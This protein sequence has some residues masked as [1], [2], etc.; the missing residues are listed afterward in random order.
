MKMK[1]TKASSKDPSEVPEVSDFI[2]SEKVLQDFLAHHQDFYEELSTLVAD[3]NQKLEAA[4]KACRQQQVSCGPFD[5]YSEREDWNF[6]ELFDRLGREL[7]IQAGGE[8][9]T[10]TVYGGNKKKLSNSL[11]LGLIPESVAEECRKIIPN[12][13]KPKKLEIP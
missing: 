13:H 9:S 3:Y 6:K 10:Q 7:F 4:E 2:I 11:E 1:T 8:M 12:Y 5:K